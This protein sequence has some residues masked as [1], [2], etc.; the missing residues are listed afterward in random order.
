MGNQTASTPAAD[1]LFEVRDKKEAKKL[2]EEKSVQFHYVVAQLLFI[3]NQACHDIQTAVAFLSMRV[4]SPDEDNWCKLKRVI[5]YLNVTRNLELRL[6]VNS[7]GSIQWY[8]INS[9]VCRCIK[10]ST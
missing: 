10:C 9:V 6:M 7:T 4:K 8:V 1:Y 5:K 2:P 3:Y